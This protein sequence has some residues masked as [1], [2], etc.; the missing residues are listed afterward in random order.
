M[1]RKGP[2]LLATDFG[3]ASRGATAQALRLARA[4]SAELLVAHA[5]EIPSPDPH[6]AWLEGAREMEAHAER[7][8]ARLAAVMRRAGATVRTQQFIGRPGTMIVRLAEK[9]KPQLLVVGTQRLRGVRR[10]LLGSVAERVLRHAPCP[11]L[12][13]TSGSRTPFKR[14]LHATDFSTRS[15]AALEEAIAIAR[16]DGSTVTLL[17]VLDERAVDAIA[18]A[19]MPTLAA[20][21]FSRTVHKESL[22]RLQSLARRHR[23]RPRVTAVWATDAASAIASQAVRERADLIAIGTQGRTGIA[24][25][26]IGNTAER[27]ARQLPCSLLCVR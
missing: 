14:I 22:E 26:L 27:I 21:R 17:N 18:M 1:K 5:V 2:I 19:A 15:D 20:G 10:F 16:A 24:G 25:F 6:G 9:V 3:P 23:L 8:L 7:S 12:V 4:R 11:V 13:A